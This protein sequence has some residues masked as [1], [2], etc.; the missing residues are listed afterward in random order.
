MRRP[1]VVGNWKLNATRV[2][3]R[4]LLSEI[5][6]ELKSEAITEAAVCVPFVF[7]SQ[8]AEQLADTSLLWGSQN[9]ADQDHGAF[10]GEI[11]A[12][13]L[14]EFGCRFAI[15]GHSERRHIYGESSALVAKRFKQA[16]TNGLQPIL[17]V[18]EA[19]EEREKGNTFDVI[20]KQLLPV[21]EI[22]GVESFVNAVVA[23]E[24]VWAIGTGRTASTEQAQQIH[25]YI[26]K[27]IAGFNQ[28]TAE[29]LRILYGGSVTADNAGAL[30]SMADIDGGL[31]GGAS[32]NAKSFLNI[33]NSAN[34]VK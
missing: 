28:S 25:T 18:G 21:I 20:E 32:L 8:V 33:I 2:S 6:V 30:F 16:I 15:I 7:I 10:T 22:A 34:S 24:P 27:T 26:R 3:T 13:M 1:L 17:C 12:S 23:Y 9:V 31:I 19:L 29:N 4:Q 14:K 11:S 5:V